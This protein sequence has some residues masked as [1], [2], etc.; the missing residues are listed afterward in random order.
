MVHVPREDPGARRVVLVLIGPDSSVLHCVPEAGNDVRVDVGPCHPERDHADLRADGIEGIG[1]DLRASL[2]C[3][4]DVRL[5]EERRI[6][7]ALGQRSDHV[8]KHDEVDLHVVLRDASPLQP[9]EDTDVRDRVGRVDQDRLADEVPGAFDGRAPRG[10][11]RGRRVLGLIQRSRRDDLDRKTP[12]LEQGSVAGVRAAELHVSG[13]ERRGKQ[14]WIGPR[15]H[16]RVDALLR[17]HAPVLRVRHHGGRLGRQERDLDLRQLGVARSCQGREQ[18]NGTEACDECPGDHWARD[19]T[20]SREAM[21][22]WSS[23]RSERNC[24][25]LRVSVCS[26]GRDRG[27]S[28]DA[29]MRPGVP[30]STSTR[31]AR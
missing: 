26:R 30:L 5:G 2:D 28:T 19:C 16:L 12:G 8:R 17:E 23:L 29:T 9:L 10:D 20:D 14:W 13:Q 1:D 15:H 21:N 3:L 22:A 7:V 18:S 11:E 31:S 6:D 25:E 24:G 4:R 27:T